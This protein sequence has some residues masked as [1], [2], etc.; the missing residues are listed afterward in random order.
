[1]NLINNTIQKQIHAI[2]VNGDTCLASLKSFAE[3][4]NYAY[5][6]FWEKTDDELQPFLQNLLDSGQLQSIFDDHE[7]YANT[8]NALLLR[9]GST[10][11]CATGKLR[12]FTVE[13]GIVNLTP[14]LEPLVTDSDVEPKPVAQPSA[15]MDG[16]SA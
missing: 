3:C 13:E 10:P 7:F 4:L 11:I 8:V 12:E 15:D 1:M 6:S 5:R 16:S 2:E 9:Y 14:I